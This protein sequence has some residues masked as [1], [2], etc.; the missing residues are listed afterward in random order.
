MKRVYHPKNKL[1]QLNWTALKPTQAKDTVF[2][3]L[4]DEKIIDK[5]DFSRLEN[6]FKVAGG[7]TQTDSGTNGFGVGAVSASDEKH[8]QV[9]E[10]RGDWP[11]GY[12]DVC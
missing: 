10:R 5:L 11:Q 12:F 7:A 9:R 8:P 2:E 3:E 1:L 6:L 4:N